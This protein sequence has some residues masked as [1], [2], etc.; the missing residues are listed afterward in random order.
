MTSAKLIAASK[1]EIHGAGY[2]ESPVEEHLKS[3][4]FAGVMIKLAK[5]R[6]APLPASTTVEFVRA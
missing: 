6:P 2:P 1:I 4:A 5:C 3:G